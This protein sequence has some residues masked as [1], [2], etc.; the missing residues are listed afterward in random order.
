LARGRDDLLNVHR[1]RRREDDGIDVG[2]FQHFVEARIE[3]QLVLFGETLHVVIDRARRTRDE[4]HPVALSRYS[5]DERAPPPA[6]SYDCRVDH[7]M[8]PRSGTWAPA[9]IVLL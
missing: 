7:P 4:P 5:L 9:R 8:S 2:R 3:L 6:E 1:V